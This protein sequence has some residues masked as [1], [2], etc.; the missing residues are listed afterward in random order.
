[1][2]Y[3]FPNIKIK[4][5]PKTFLKDVHIGMLFPEVPLSDNLQK[6]AGEF[7]A[8]EFG[9]PKIM[10]E[11]MPKAVSVFSNAREI[12]FAFGLSRADLIIKREA[13]RS[14]ADIQDLLNKYFRFL[15]AL[16]IDYVSKLIFSKYNELGYETQEGLPVSKVMVDVFSKGLLTSMTPKDIETQKDLTRWEKVIHSEGDD[17]TDSFFTI[18]Y[19]FRKLPIEKGR[20][21]LTLKTIIESRNVNIA[22]KD[23]PSTMLYYNQ[24]LDN[25]FHWCVSNKVLKAMREG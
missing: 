2:G 1:M 10:M 24:I 23:L 13:Y 15:S 19:G 17:E 12:S 4:V 5:Y 14:F 7:F 25:A 20:S 11:E 6:S 9:L 16:G 18:E 21:S 8:A 22:A 3:P